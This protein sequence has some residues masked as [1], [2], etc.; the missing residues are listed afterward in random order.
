MSERNTKEFFLYFARS[1]PLRTILMVALLVG[2]GLAEGV[3]IAGLLPLLEIGLTSPG[4]EPSGMSR[5]VSGLLETVGL[6]PTLG[7]LLLI[8]VGAMA[9][10]GLL[11][12]LAM[13]QVGYVVARVAMDLRLRLIRALMKADWAY[14]ATRPVGYFSNSISSEAHR[15]ASAYR[16]ACNALADLAQA[17][18]YAVIVVLVSP[19]PGRPAPARVLVRCR[20]V[21]RSR[22]P[23]RWSER[24]SGCTRRGHHL[25]LQSARRAAA[26]CCR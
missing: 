1:N 21:G 6:K 10:K 5:A 7:I 19:A 15:S 9:M 22:T 4:T 26:P 14:F 12:W 23:L 25:R 16:M 18:V 3:G 2:A 24:R 17:A 13:R 20:R 8:V 11:R